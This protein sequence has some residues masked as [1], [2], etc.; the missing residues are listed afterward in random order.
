MLFLGCGNRWQQS[1]YTA[2]ELKSLQQGQNH[3]AANTV[4]L[5]KST[6]P[7]PLAYLEWSYVH[8]G[9]FDFVYVITAIY[10]VVYLQ[11]AF[12]RLKELREL[13]NL[14][15]LPF[16]HNSQQACRSYGAI[17]VVGQV[18]WKRGSEERLKGRGMDFLGWIFS[19]ICL[20]LLVSPD[21][22]LKGDVPTWRSFFQLTCKFS[23]HI[24]IA[25]TVKSTTCEIFESVIFNNKGQYHALVYI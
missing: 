15:S 7:Q 25:S 10:R 1:H 13:L 5:A 4:T 17:C 8:D 14:A 3:F 23:I 11:W 20:L 6:H 16:T 9:C 18:F 2:P 22:A 19:R 24:F 21:P 12:N